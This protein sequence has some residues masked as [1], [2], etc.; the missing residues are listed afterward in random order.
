MKCWKDE[1]K[2]LEMILQHWLEKNDVE[3]DLATL[4]ENLKDLQ[5]KG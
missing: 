5:G 3:K 2:Q 4:K 1:E